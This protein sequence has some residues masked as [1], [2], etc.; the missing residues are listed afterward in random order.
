LIISLK[1]CSPS[2][3][4]TSLSKISLF[5]SNY[6]ALLFKC[7]AEFL[8]RFECN[9]AT[10]HLLP[11]FKSKNH[12]SLFNFYWEETINSCN[13]LKVWLRSWRWV[14]KSASDVWEFFSLEMNLEK[15]NK[16][17]FV[18]QGWKHFVY[19]L[20][21]RVELSSSCKASFCNISCCF[22]RENYKTIE[23]FHTMASQSSSLS[24]NKLNL[25]PTQENLSS[26]LLADF[27]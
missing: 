26:C 9:I 7:Q 13:S 24:K 6:Q 22:T 14:R 16:I 23:F 19:F 15:N 5:P 3:K 25:R 12:L 20:S 27:P 18:Q 1:Y 17:F 21:Q 10:N 8:K 2:S 4:I 11:S